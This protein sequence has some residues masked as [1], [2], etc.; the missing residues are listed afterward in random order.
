MVSRSHT[1]MFLLWCAVIGSL[2]LWV[3]VSFVL[4]VGPSLSWVL[5]QIPL[6][7]ML[8]VIGPAL[9]EVVFRGYFFELIQRR[10]LSVWLDRLIIRVSVANLVTTFAFVLM[11]V[12][13]RGIESGLMVVV[14]SLILGRIKEVY[15]GVWF[16]IIVHAFWNLGWFSLFPPLR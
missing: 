6:F 8:C 2:A 14:P 11:H 9:E 1:S 5:D 4:G 3:G 13:F 7:L 12:F 16:C 15:G 10:Q